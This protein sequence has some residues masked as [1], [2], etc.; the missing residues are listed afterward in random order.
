MKIIPTKLL[1]PVCFLSDYQ[2]NKKYSISQAENLCVCPLFLS[3]ARCCY[4]VLYLNHYC[5]ESTKEKILGK[6]WSRYHICAHTL[7]ILISLGF[8]VVVLFM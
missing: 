8:E 5:S 4:N 2:C 6:H 3:D 7:L 1:R